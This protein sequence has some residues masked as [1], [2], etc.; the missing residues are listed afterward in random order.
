MAGVG[1]R[2]TKARGDS[3]NGLQAII[4]LRIA[5]ENGPLFGGFEKQHT[6]KNDPWYDQNGLLEWGGSK[7]PVSISLKSVQHWWSSCSSP[8]YISMQVRKRPGLGPIWRWSL[9]DSLMDWMNG[10]SS[11]HFSKEP[12]VNALGLSDWL[13]SSANSWWNPQLNHTERVSQFLSCIPCLEH[14]G[15]CSEHL[16][17]QC[18]CPHGQTHLHLTNTFL[19]YLS[20]STGGYFWTLTR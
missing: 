1:C 4:G 9:K 14:N 8:K 15:A 10:G 7:R 6:L 16:A 19:L 13:S 17:S 5:M 11:L 12:H 2:K 20:S 3:K 18:W